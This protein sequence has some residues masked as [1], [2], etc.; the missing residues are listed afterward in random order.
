MTYTCTA[1]GETR[2]EAIAKLVPPDPTT[3]MGKDGTAVGE[4]AS[5]EAAEKAITTMKSDTDPKGSVFGKL[6][7]RQSKVTS[8]SI[9]IAWTKVTGAKKYVVYANKCGKTTKPKKITTTT[10]TTYTLKKIAKKKLTKGTYYKFIV[11]A[12]DSKG[13]V[14]SSSKLIHI[15]TS[16][17]KVGNPLK[18]TTKAKKD[19]V[20]VKVKKTFKL[21]GAYTSSK[22]LPVKKH[23]AI[24]YETSNK[25][26]ATVT[27]KGVIKGIKKGTCYVYVYAQNG[28]FKKI[29]V[30]VKR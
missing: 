3:E 21:A 17:G 14:V 13:K 19:R 10:K 16:G 12:L 26:I 9:K 4:G 2:T 1:C 7:L 24:R 28:L 8:T 30:T 22:K 25:K 23:V 11:V 20:T 29:K 5:A 6:T 18:I 27:S 15:A